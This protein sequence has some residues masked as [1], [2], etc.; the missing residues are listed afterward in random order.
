MG[1]LMDLCKL[2]LKII[3]WIQAVTELVNEYGENQKMVRKHIIHEPDF[4][5]IKT[6]FF[7]KEF[8]NCQISQKTKSN[9]YNVFMKKSTTS[10]LCFL[11]K[12]L[13]TPIFLFFLVDFSRCQDKI[14]P[15][16]THTSNNYK[17]LSLS[18]Y[19]LCSQTVMAL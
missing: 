15:K 8:T 6:G 4:I 3:Q 10:K 12:I 16:L 9:F 14:S 17:K 2:L 1:R 7:K 13:S 11:N 19:A 5:F 18:S